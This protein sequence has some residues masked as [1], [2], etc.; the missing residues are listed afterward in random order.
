MK[1]FILEDELLLVVNKKTRSYLEEVISDYV[2][3]NYRSAIVVLYSVVVYDLIAKLRVLDEIY[4]DNIAKDILAKIKDEQEK[5][6]NSPKWEKILFSEI[7][8][9]TELLN[10]VESSKIQQLVDDRNFSAHPLYNNNFELINPHAE[11]IRYH[12]RNMLE[13]IFQKEPLL[14]KK[15]TSEFINSINNFYEK[16]GFNGFEEYLKIHFFNK[17]NNNVKKELFKVLW[18]FIFVLEN[19]ECNE[20]RALNLQALISLTKGNEDLFFNIINEELSYYNNIG[21]D[22]YKCDFTDKDFSMG[23]SRI[24]AL[25]EFLC[26]YPKFFNLLNQSCKKNIEIMA[27]RNINFFSLSYFL[28]SNLKE[29]V[30]KIQARHKD[31]YMDNTGWINTSFYN[32]ISS[33]VFLKLYKIAKDRDVTNQFIRFVIGYFGK[34]VTWIAATEI[35]Y[36]IISFIVEDFKKSQLLNLLRKMNENNQIYGNRELKKEMDDLKEISKK[37]IG[38]NFNPSEFKRLWK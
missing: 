22:D 17:F 1:D 20:N 35:Y 13:I 32:C 24:V 6:P 18:K 31:A 9:R 12:L 25:I 5:Y 11:N 23:E 21:P 8:D 10:P 16:Q 19:I 37:I 4:S 34:A 27:E 36:E 26:I 2:N 30:D 29:H 7:S 3:G 33:E 15:I 14:S 28:S 38:K